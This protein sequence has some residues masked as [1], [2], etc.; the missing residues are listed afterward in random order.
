MVDLPLMELLGKPNSEAPD[1]Q[2]RDKRKDDVVDRSR[3]RCW[4]ADR[5]VVKNLTTILLLVAWV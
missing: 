2:G 5:P 1:K 4:R 3:M